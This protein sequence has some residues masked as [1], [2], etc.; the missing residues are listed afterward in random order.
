M[1]IDFSSAIQI[2]ESYLRKI[3]LSVGENLVNNRI[4]ETNYGWCF[5]YQSQEYI[6]TRNIIYALAGNGPV[7]VDKEA[8]KISIFG[9]AYPIEYYINEIGDNLIEAL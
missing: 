7:Y 2:F 4:L 8:G 5:F 3:E 9:T 1:S 6:D